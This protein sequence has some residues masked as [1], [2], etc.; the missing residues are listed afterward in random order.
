MSLNS[1]SSLQRTD[2]SGQLNVFIVLK[3]KSNGSLKIVSREDLPPSLRNGRLV[4]KQKIVLRDEARNNIEGEIMYMRQYQS[5]LRST[6]LDRLFASSFCFQSDADREQCVIFE[7]QP[8]EQSKLSGTGLSSK[9]KS[10]TSRLISKP[11]NVQRRETGTHSN[12]VPASIV[13]SINAVRS[14]SCDKQPTGTQRTPHP[15]SNH[16]Q[17][18][19]TFD[20]LDD[21]ASS[22]EIHSTRTNNNSLTFDDNDV[23]DMMDDSVPTSESTDNDILLD[24]I[25]SLSAKASQQAILIKEKDALIKRLRSTMIGIDS[26]LDQMQNHSC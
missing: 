17:Q 22:I 16:Q 14:S 13:P 19:M 24:K 12:V 21:R 1:S 8:M 18:T 15:E 20:D 4:L 23:D 11:P 26:P 6:F 10:M 5:V 3:L 7:K 9:A 25:K 2:S